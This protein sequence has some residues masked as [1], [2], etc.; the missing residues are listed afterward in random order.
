MAGRRQ[1][2][3]RRGAS[4]HADR[5]PAHHDGDHAGGRGPVYGLLVID[6]TLVVRLVF[7]ALPAVGVALSPR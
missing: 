7:P 4:G 2:D 6:W 5:G 3:R 1:H